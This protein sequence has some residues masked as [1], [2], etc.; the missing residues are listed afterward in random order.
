MFN[1]LYI[2]IDAKFNFF[3]CLPEGLKYLT[4]EYRFNQPINNFPKSL[5]F[6]QLGIKFNHPIDRLPQNLTHLIIGWNFNHPIVMF[7]HII[8]LLPEP[9]HLL[10][11]FVARVFP[12]SQA[13]RSLFIIL[14]YMI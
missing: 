1:K 3:K 14:K 5:I 8:I 4:L 11:D 9:T 12:I 13:R 2:S 10:R 6:L 7:N